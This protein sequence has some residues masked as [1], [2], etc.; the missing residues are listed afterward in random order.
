MQEKQDL[1]GYIKTYFFWA[2]DGTLFQLNYFHVSDS[3]FFYS[4]TA[5]VSFTSSWSSHLM[6]INVSLVGIGSPKTQI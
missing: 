1:V 5:Q 2:F 6:E 3:W 4:T